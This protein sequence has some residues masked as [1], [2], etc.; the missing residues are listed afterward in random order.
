MRIASVNSAIAMIV[1][2]IGWRKFLPDE[3]DSVT[4]F[5]AN[6]PVLKF[7][8]VHGGEYAAPLTKEGPLVPI[9]RPSRLAN[10][11]C[12][13]SQGLGESIWS[14]AVLLWQGWC[15]AVSRWLARSCPS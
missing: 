13:V 1:L 11:T 2:S 9:Q 6:S 7:F 8:N 12:A 10:R 5:V 15:R 4:V 3:G 14:P